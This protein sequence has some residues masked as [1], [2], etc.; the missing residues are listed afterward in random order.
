MERRFEN[1]GAA[2]AYAAYHNRSVKRVR[3]L[4]DALIF[5]IGNC[6]YNSLALLQRPGYSHGY[7]HSKLTASYSWSRARYAIRLISDKKLRFLVEKEDW[8]NE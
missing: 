3:L 7:Y 8:I 2:A 6:V 5:A 1:Q 4:F